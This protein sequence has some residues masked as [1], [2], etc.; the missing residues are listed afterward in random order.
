MR[1][2]N[3]GGKFTGT[4]TGREYSLYSTLDFFLFA[5]NCKIITNKEM[6]Q[7]SI[8]I[9]LKNKLDLVVGN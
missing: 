7:I 6:N 1:D 4:T 9:S 5:L 3:S 8:T 2:P